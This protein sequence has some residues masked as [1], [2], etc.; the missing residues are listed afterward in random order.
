M[1]KLRTH[2]PHILVVG[3]LML[4]HYLW[5]GINRISPEAPVAV[6][7]I[8]KEEVTLGGAGNVVNNLT[9]L[10]C[11]VGVL[12]AIGMDD[13][14]KELK[15]MLDNINATSYLILQDDRKTSKKSRVIA[16]NQQI[17]RYDKESKN[18]ITKES[19]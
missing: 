6:V 17:I 1:E 8:D 10:G 18:D 19:E 2:K 4:D 16:S 3:D 9:A 12:S 11:Q 13:V 14:G 5:G 7:D 15:N